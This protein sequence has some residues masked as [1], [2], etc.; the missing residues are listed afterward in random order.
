M[1]KIE[2]SKNGIIGIDIVDNCIKLSDGEY[3]LEYIDDG[4]YNFSFKISG[5]VELIECGFDR[6]L[7]INN[8]YDIENGNLKLTKFY[9][10]K[11]VDEIDDINLCSSGVKVDYCFS[12]I[13]RCE[14][15]YVININHKF[16]NTVS[17]IINKSVALLNS[18]IKFIINSNVYKDCV[19]SILDQNT[20]IITMGECDA[21]I[22]PNMFIDLDD[23][24]AR[25]G[26]VIG[27]FKSDQVFYLMSKGI[28]YND[29]IKLLIKGFLIANLD[30]D[31]EL[32]FR[33]IDI[34]DMYWR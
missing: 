18:K 8:T 17:N 25:H 12:N 14:E 29:T 1:N 24:E 3:F 20:R 21:S 30:V 7:V 27:S 23:V 16:K 28:S 31:F 15:K 13:C 5:N 9:N 4:K 19:K 6:K 2:V 33:I 11:T 10:N 32:R 34:I 22:S 26:S